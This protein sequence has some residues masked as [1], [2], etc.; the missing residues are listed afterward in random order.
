MLYSLFVTYIN[1]FSVFYK[2]CNH[3]RPK[4]LCC[5]QHV[6][7]CSQHEFSE[8]FIVVSETLLKQKA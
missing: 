2:L 4:K 1:V 8:I 3:Q 7:E 6:Q 5:F